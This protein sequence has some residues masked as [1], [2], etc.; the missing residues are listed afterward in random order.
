MPTATGE[1]QMNIADSH[2]I[3]TAI[4]AH[5][6]STTYRAQA[7]ADLIVAL[8][9]AALLVAALLHYALPCATDGALCMA[10]VLHTRTP[11]PRRLL[12][13][14]HAA[15]VRWRIASARSEITQIQANIPPRIAA[16][17]EWIK[18]QQATLLRLTGTAH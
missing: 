2:A 15:W 5:N 9:I 14:L 13:S 16:H 1:L 10:A 12:G 7:A 3:A 17:E 11:W 4:N 6:A 8:V 18:D